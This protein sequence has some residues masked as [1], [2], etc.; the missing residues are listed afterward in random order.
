M[1]PL[2]RAA[3][4]ALLIAP[5]ASA[6][7][8]RSISLPRVPEPDSTCVVAKLSDGDSFRCKD[9]RTVRLLLIDTPEL[10]QRPWGE[11]ARKKLDS[12][13]G[14]GTTL[15]LEFDRSTTDRYGRLL[16]YAWKDSVMVNEW[17]VAHGWAVVL[18]YENVRYLERMQRAERSAQVMKRGFWQAWAFRCRPVNFR[19]RRCGEFP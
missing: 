16:A 9:G 6:L 3:C 10:A 1:S 13:A 5:F 2:H 14:P 4:C 12:L 7:G 11:M 8:H 15:R 19:A 18:K 17:M